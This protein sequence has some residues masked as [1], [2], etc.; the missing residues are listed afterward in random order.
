MI[1]KDGSNLVLIIGAMKSGTT[2]L[3]KFLSQHPDIIATTKTE[4]HFF[5]NHFD[6]GLDNY[7]AHW[8]EVS[9]TDKI[10]L[11]ASPTYFKYHL[12]VDVPK[13]IFKSYP[14]ARLICILRDPIKRLESNY[15]QYINDSGITEGI[16]THIPDELLRSSMYFSQMEKY[17][18]YFNKNQIKVIRTSELHSNPND[19]LLS[20]CNFINVGPYSFNDLSVKY[21]DS[22]VTN[23]SIYQNLRKFKILKTLVKNLPQNYKYAIIRKLS[24]SGER[25]SNELCKLN[26]INKDKLLKKFEKERAGIKR[27]FNIDIFD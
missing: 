25:I 21:G 27:E 15:R 5:S 11:E 6:K 26:E 16:N 12:H 3:F 23:T 22:Q 7:I 9:S 20:V 8:P 17:L 1:K 19:I 2:S 4:T 14:K 13:K 24:G 18:E 10:Y